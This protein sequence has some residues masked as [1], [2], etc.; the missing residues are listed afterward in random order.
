MGKRRKKRPKSVVGKF[1]NSFIRR[2]FADASEKNAA[3]MKPDCKTKAVN[4]I[5]LN[6]KI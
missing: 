6:S 3:E 2:E 5:F 1:R 4:L